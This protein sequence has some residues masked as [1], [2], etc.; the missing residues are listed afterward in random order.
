M[1]DVPRLNILVS[2]PYLKPDVIEELKKIGPALRLVVDSGAFTAFQ[3]GKPIQLDDYCRFI[4]TLPITP[5]RYFTLDVIGDAKRSMENYE[6]MLKRGFKPVPIFTRGEHPSVLE[7]YYRTSDVVGLG[8]LVGTRNNGGYIRG[9]MKHIGDR[10]EH[11]LGFA[12]GNFIKHFRP[13]M[14]DANS[15]ESG[16][17]YGRIPIYLGSGNMITATRKDFICKPHN[18]IVQAIKQFNYDPVIFAQSANWSGG[19]TPIRRMGAYSYTLY[20]ID[21]ERVLGTRMFL[22]SNS[23]LALSL[24][25]SG[26]KIALENNL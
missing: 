21:C 20:S 25:H 1:A 22:A 8:G 19:D 7:D 18:K 14:C 9:M 2:Y 11:W 23:G 15:W 24:I 17:R 5:W 3:S 6:L 26:F 13:Y 12:I 4:E 16:G 10:K